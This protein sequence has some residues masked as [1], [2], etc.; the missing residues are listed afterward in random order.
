MKKD[1]FFTR[2]GFFKSSA[3]GALG[4]VSVPSI[5]TSCSGNAQKEEKLKDVTVPEILKT[6][7]D[8]KALKAGLVGCG[9]RGT[10]AACNFIDAGSG[11]QITALGD[12]FPDKMD[13]CRKTLKD[14]GQDIPDENCFIGF[15]AYQ[16]VIDSG[17]D[18]VLLCTPPVFRPLHF[19][20]AIEKN[21]H[22]FI[23]KPCAVDPAGAKRMLVTGKKA[24]QKGLSVISGTIRRSQKD[25]IETYRRVAGG[26]IGEIVSAH[27]IRHGSS[28]WHIQRRPEW[29]DMEYML[30]N[31][32]NFCWTSGDLIAEQFVH[33]IDLMSWFMGDKHPVRAEATGGRQ[34]RVTGD[35]Y[36]F[37]SV[38]FAYENGI[39]THCTSRQIDGC[40]NNHSILVYG[41]KGYTNCFDTI[42]NLDGSVAW[43]YPHPKPE[44]ADQSMA[45]PDPFV[46]EHI[47]L[48]TAIRTNKAVNDSEQHV[49]STLM[50]IM[51]RESA[52]SGKFVTWDQIVASNLKLGPDNY[53]FG[54]VS[55]IK[56]EIPVV[57]DGARI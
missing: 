43:K 2:R 40:D 14:K 3:I 51:G 1:E 25:C 50:A 37:F 54:P 22:C 39:R 48:V 20:Y 16:K 38:E 53:E 57:G 4:A 42:F 47:R 11:L 5:L 56:E 7:P 26:A 35:M 28:L 23:E 55:G 15:D 24:T 29:T 13:A 19:E 6:A 18:V 44:D 45:V 34:R 21:K 52:Y 12:V 31:W 49:N 32:V 9:G 41:T 33:E 46:Q 36:D 10:G 30:R 17:V 27:V 8:G